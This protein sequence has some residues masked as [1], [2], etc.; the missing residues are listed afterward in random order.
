MKL[1]KAAKARVKRMNMGERKAVLKAAM[2][3]ADNEM[4][5]PDRYAAIHRTLSSSNKLC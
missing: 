5:T 3:M 1:S 4:I 2:L